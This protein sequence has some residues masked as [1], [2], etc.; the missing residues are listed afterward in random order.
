MSACTYLA[1]MLGFCLSEHS[2]REIEQMSCIV[3]QHHS[4]AAGLRYNSFVQLGPGGTEGSF[5]L[6]NIHTSV[7]ALLCRNEW[8]NLDSLCDR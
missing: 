6:K 8:A 7:K 4:F 1:D 2:L 3:T 5:F